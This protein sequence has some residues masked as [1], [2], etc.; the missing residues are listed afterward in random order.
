MAIIPLKQTVTVRKL[1]TGNNDGWDTEEWSEPITLN[2]RAEETVE[3]V[4]NQFDEEVVSSLRLYFDK[5]PDIDYETEITFEN[6]LGVK[7]QR[8]P[9]RIAPVRMINGKVALTLINL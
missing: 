3:T 9:I 5:L 6:E 2:C 4:K 8:T 1:I 7:I